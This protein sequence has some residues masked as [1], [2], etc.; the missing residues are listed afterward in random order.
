MKVLD[1]VDPDKLI[2]NQK[3]KALRAVNLIKQKRNGTVKRRMCEN[4]APHRKFVPREEGRSPT[5]SLKSLMALLMINAHEK[6]A[7]SIFDVPGAYLQTE[8]PKSKFVLLLLEGQ[9]VDFMVEIN[10][11]YTDGVRT[12]NGKNALYLW[13]LKTIYGMIEF[14]LLW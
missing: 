9:Y 2:S 8:P 3:R 1:G 13:I 4:G 14:T 6:R 11:E 5:M 10:P 12:V 7:V